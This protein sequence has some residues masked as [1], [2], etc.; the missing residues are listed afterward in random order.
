[1]SSYKRFQVVNQIYETGL[2]PLMYHPDLETMKQILKAVYDGG[3]KLFEFTS[4]GDFAHEVFAPLKKYAIKELPGMILGVGSIIDAPTA[5][6]F[7]QSGADFVVSP[8]F[9][10]EIARLCNRRKILWVPGCATVSE[11]SQAE[12][13]GAEFVKIFPAG[14]VGGPKYVSAVKGPLPWLS[15]MVTGGVEATEENISQWFKAGVS[16]VGMGSNLVTKELVE[17][18]NFD[19]L[20]QK[21]KTVLEII[22]KYKK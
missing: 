18:Q 11:I 5:A 3:C 13:M 22:N 14:E 10:P 8:L 21:V 17:S 12:E 2:V 15:I 9:N 19:L 6:M 1:M 20:T 16:C 7:I 4:R